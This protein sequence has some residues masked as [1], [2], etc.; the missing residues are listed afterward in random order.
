MGY[1]RPTWHLLPKQSWDAADR[2]CRVLTTTWVDGRTPGQILRQARRDAAAAA[3]ARATPGSAS[4]PQQQPQPQQQQQQQPTT[5]NAGQL[6]QLVTMGVE[7]SL[8]QLVTTG[9]LHADPHPGNLL[10]TPQGQLAYIDF[11]LLVQVPPQASLVR[12]GL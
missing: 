1:G 8:C 11:G 2:G 6:L 7:A 12:N 4:K 3:A 9:V 10:L 5:D